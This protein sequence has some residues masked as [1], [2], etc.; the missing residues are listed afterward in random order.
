M[1]TLE[2]RLRAAARAAAGTVADGSAPPLRLPRAAR[3]L[4][5]PARGYARY[6]WIVPLAAAAAVIAVVAGSVFAAHA[7]VPGTRRPAPGPPSGPLPLLADGVPAYFLASPI[8]AGGAQPGLLGGGPSTIPRQYRTHETLRIMATA[9]GKVAATATLPGY[10]TET[11][12]SSGAFFAAVVRDNAARFFEIRLD[13]SHTGATVTELP[14]P[15]D[16][17]TMGFMAASADGSRLAYETLAPGS[18]SGGQHLVIASTTD[19]SERQWAAFA[20]GFEGSM[21]MLSWLANDRTLAFSWINPGASSPPSSL[22]LLDTAAP[23]SNL[24]ASKPVLPFATPAG[25][26]GAYAV[27]ANGKVVVGA[28]TARG[29]GEV[30]GVRVPIGSL[31]AFSAAT[32]KPTL[33]YPQPHNGQVTYC[34]KTPLWISDSGRQVLIDCLQQREAA[35]GATRGNPVVRVLLL[36]GGQVTYL[37]WL[38]ATSSEITAFPG[39]LFSGMPADFAGYPPG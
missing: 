34:G 9:T 3:R 38:A 12:A 7:V 30:D 17:A 31:V 11:A 13:V 14:I 26:F 39:S 6:P 19:G 33:L 28:V 22:R 21:G 25:S 2:D 20:R 37:P 35:D 5:W 8:S 32:R 36:D 27:S 18:P 23:G 24:T 29:P 16:T 1:N 4:G 10:V 15:P